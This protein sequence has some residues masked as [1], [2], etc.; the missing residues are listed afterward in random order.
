[1]T[2]MTRMSKYKD[3]R[4]GI[5]TDVISNE[6]ATAY[7]KKEEIVKDADYYKRFLASE[8]AA[9]NQPT[10]LKKASTEDTLVESLT[11]DTINSQVDEELERALTRVRQ[12]SGQEDFNTRMDILNKI[13]QSKMV[14]EPEE[15][16]EEAPEMDFE[17]VLE[18]DEDDDEEE[19]TGSRFGFFKRNKDE[20]DDE[21]DDDFE[22]DD[23]EDDDSQKKHFGF[24][25]RHKDDDDDDE[26]EFYDDEDDDDDEEEGNSTFVKVLNG[27]IVVLGLVLVALVGYIVKEF[28][29]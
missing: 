12:D 18:E 23:E 22:E 15:V 13:R 16:E 4:E 26:E 25:K 14:S 11:L 9:I 1:M 24:F 2:K 17:D 28:L 6:T 8:E 21:D 10:Q 3:L 29:L 5:K 27:I 20:E 7:T 19:N